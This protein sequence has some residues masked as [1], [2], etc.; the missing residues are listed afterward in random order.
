MSHRLGSR[1]GWFVGLLAALSLGTGCKELFES[2]LDDGFEDE[3]AGNGV[4]ETCGRTADCRKGLVCESNG[5]DDVCTFAGDTAK[6]EDCVYTGQ[7]APGLYCDHTRTC[8]DAGTVVAGG[9]C[10]TDTDCS[11][12]T[13]C[14]LSGLSA[15]CVATGDSDLGATCALTSDC[16]AGLTCG[17]GVDGS[18]CTTPVAQPEGTPAS[19]PVPLWAGGECGPDATSPTAYFDVPRG[20]A[21]LPDFYRLPFPNDLRLGDDG[22]D[23]SGH[24]APPTVLNVPIIQRYLDALGDVDGFST[25]PV[26]Y[27]RFSEAYDWDD[28]RGN[29]LIVDITSG[30]PTYG[31]TV[32]I[33]WFTT[34]GQV[35][36]YICRNW[37]SFAPA[38]GTPLLAGTTYAAIVKTSVRSKE[39]QA[40][41]RSNDLNALLST[42]VPGNADLAAAHTKYAALRA[43][44][45]D[46]ANGEVTSDAVLNAA[47]FTTQN[48][49]ALIAP[50][51][52]AVRADTMP[53]V[54]N[55]TVCTAS[56]TVSPC[57]ADGDT[58]RVCGAPNPNFTE[59]HGRIALPI[60][61]QGEA[62]YE[63]IGEGGFELDGTGKP[64]IARH[65]NVCFA[66]TI[67]KTA[68]P[69]DG[70][71]LMLYG[72]GTGGSFTNA[73]RGGLAADV[74]DSAT[75][76]ATL[77]IDMPQHGARR[78]EST[79]GSDQLFFNFLNPPAARDNVLQGSADLMTLVRWATTFSQ[80]STGTG[81]EIRFNPDRISLF[82]HSQ[83]SMHATLMF[84]Y[85]PD[86]D[87]VLLSGNGGHLTS[88]MLTKE[89]PI[90]IKAV[91]PF[92]LLDADGNG[93]L[94]G[95]VFHPM[96]AI[97]QTYFDRV[98]SV[99]FARR[100]HTSPST[101]APDGH[102]VFMTY[103]LGDTYST[104]ETMTAY[105]RAG[106]LPHVTPALANLDLP[107]SPAPLSA[108]VAFDTVDRTIGLR[109]Y[110]PTS[111]EDGHFVS[112][113]TGR[114]DVLRFMRQALSGAVPTIGQ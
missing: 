75:G 32:P 30:S 92:A 67:P 53:A 58:E 112:T 102:H 7:C 33:H 36:K 1:N 84:P 38:V 62:P 72:H 111:G 96:L 78:G 101:L 28:V 2:G 114:D 39:N 20:G 54:S 23:M 15:T 97:F 61:Q 41:E 91:V 34:A 50:L 76:A 98:D 57:A 70:F 16:L 113:D 21:L 13:L 14:A 87:A 12:G 44:L 88:S 25:N 11:R 4:G 37:L 80:A 3:I 66:L 106:R 8:N 69:T 68:I 104:E 49:E 6:G 31:Q 89:Q 74:S 43:W 19:P 64:T 90:N 56:T 59:I 65:E 94:A 47:V 27:F 60:F 51:R 77:A 109:Q 63:T 40:F 48:P 93:K 17:S 55:L 18:V 5:T 45:A 22:I 107:E 105:A 110:D 108:N 73:V 42:T 35:S 83:G 95:G 46:S 10:L 100:V 24:P 52:E 26:M 103:G 79:R 82:A 29:I 71:P 99:N 86:L 85:E 9:G 81:G